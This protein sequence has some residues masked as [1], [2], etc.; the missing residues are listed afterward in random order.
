MYNLPSIRS[1]R[2]TN[3]G[4]GNRKEIRNRADMINPSPDTYNIKTCFDMN[5]FHRKGA[6]LA[7]K[8]NDGFKSQ[9]TPGPGQY[10]LVNKLKDMPIIIKSRLGF[11]YD[12]ELR[13]KK[14]CVSMQKYKPKDTLVKG[15]RY[16]RITFGYGNRA[17]SENSC[18]IYN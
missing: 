13:E 14:H 9:K 11:Y 6:K 18:I 16:S 12:K 2:S 4:I 7:G 3:M 15:S 17:S 5:I 8:A 1:K 10:T